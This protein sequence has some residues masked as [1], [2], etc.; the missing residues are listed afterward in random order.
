[1]ATSDR[2]T[3]VTN[4][5]A[6]PAVRP[7]APE[8]GEFG[9]RADH[10]LLNRVQ[11]EPHGS[12]A[13]DAACEELVGRYQA[14]VRSCVLRY[15]DSPEAQEELMQVG[16]V[17]LLKAINNF[18][19]DI[20]ESLAA[21]ATPCIAGEIKR[22]FR[23]KRWQVHV[24]RSA[25]ELR[26]EIRKARSDL[27]QRLSRTPT[28][29]EL[30]EHLGVSSADLLDAQRADLAFQA[31]SLS[32]PL[33][34]GTDAGTLE[35]LLGGDDPQLETALEMEAV[36]GHLGELPDREQ[37]LLMMRFY[38]NMTQSEIGDQLGISQM[39]VSRLLAHA[40]GYLRDRILE[41]GEQADRNPR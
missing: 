27:A 24:R 14:L 31:S 4:T 1:M 18:D 6:S 39:H 2:Q 23:D 5:V 3:E 33:A 36:W 20:G 21:Y 7:T 13:H 28:D 34:E 8:P 35:E 16:Y 30:A 12:R 32:A 26:L 25:Q 19:A 17:G 22:H 11:S 37:R 10:E 9:D 38:G 40:L 29:S 41:S 15:R